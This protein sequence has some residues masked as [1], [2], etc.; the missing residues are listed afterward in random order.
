MKNLLAGLKGRLVQPK[1]GIHEF[2]EKII[3]IIKSEKQ[4]KKI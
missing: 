3:K 4:K 2:E 1:E